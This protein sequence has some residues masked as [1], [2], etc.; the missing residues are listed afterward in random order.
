ML[1]EKIIFPK[2]WA[3]IFPKRWAILSFFDFGIEYVKGENNS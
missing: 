3:I 1:K 2:W